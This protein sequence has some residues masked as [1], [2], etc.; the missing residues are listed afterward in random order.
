MTDRLERLRQVQGFGEGT[1]G[2]S[3]DGA[4]QVRIVSLS[5][6]VLEMAGGP[7]AEI[8]IE[9]GEDDAGQAGFI[10]YESDLERWADGAEVSAAERAEI[11]R[12]VALALRADGLLVWREDGT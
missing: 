8:E 6:A 11:A 3:A 12:I 5:A 7:R 2:A 10:L 1:A 9:R 4:A